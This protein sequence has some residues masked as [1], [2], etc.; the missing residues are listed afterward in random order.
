MTDKIPTAKD[1]LEARHIEGSEKRCAAL[2]EFA[3][4]HVQAALESAYSKAQV[5]M[6]QGLDYYYE[7]YVEGVDKNSILNSYPETF[8]K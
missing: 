3:K 4:L 2:I 1:F 6:K 5:T 7:D 8:I